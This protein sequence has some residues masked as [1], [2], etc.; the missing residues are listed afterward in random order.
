M[1]KETKNKLDP[2]AIAEM[3]RGIEPVDWVQM[4]LTA[5]L[6]EADRVLAGI[7]V[8]AFARA[9]LRGS[10]ARRFPELSRSELNMKVLTYLTPVRM[11]ER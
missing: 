5:N 7:R 1:S 3:V 9:A 11:E 10:F 4:R 6:S 8:A 2:S